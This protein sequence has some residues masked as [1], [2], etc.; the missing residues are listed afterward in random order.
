LIVTLSLAEKLLSAMGLEHL[1]GDTLPI[2]RNP[3]L[4]KARIEQKIRDERLED[5]T[6]Y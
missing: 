1:L 4:T 5:L 2:E 6:G 3:H